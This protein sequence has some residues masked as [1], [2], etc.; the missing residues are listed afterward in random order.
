MDPYIQE[1]KRLNGTPFPDQ[2][3]KETQYSG[4]IREIGRTRDGRIIWSN[5]VCGG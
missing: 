4:T 3:I 1:Q 5:G 2:R